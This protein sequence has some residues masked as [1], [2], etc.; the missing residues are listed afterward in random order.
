MTSK[1]KRSNKIRKAP[2]ARKYVTESPLARMVRNNLLNVYEHTAADEIIAAYQM[3]AGLP[4]AR[5]PSLNIPQALRFDA[6]DESAARRSD[7]LRIFPVWKAD[8][9]G[10]RELDVT[11]GVLIFDRDPR[12]LDEFFHVRRG[13]CRD[14]LVRGLRHFAALR[15]NTPRGVSGWKMDPVAA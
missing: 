12:H 9:K 1:P 6:A 14:C 4:V 13:T 5:D 7:L 3:D 2:G 8:L 15:G 10:T 11:L